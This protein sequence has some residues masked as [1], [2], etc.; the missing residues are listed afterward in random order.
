MGTAEDE[1]PNGTWVV[2]E[3]AADAIE[4]MEV[5]AYKV[6]NSMADPTESPATIN[7]IVKFMDTEV[8]VIELSSAAGQALNSME[9]VEQVEEKAVNLS[10][11]LCVISKYESHNAGKDLIQVQAYFARDRRAFIVTASIDPAAASGLEEEVM[12]I[13]K[14]FKTTEFTR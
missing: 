14:T 7:V 2:S 11:D 8:N 10:G 9:G 6:A 3:E 12:G 13:V 1:I 5:F 4:G